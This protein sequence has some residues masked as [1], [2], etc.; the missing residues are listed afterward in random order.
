MLETPRR[1]SRPF[2]ST[3]DPAFRQVAATEGCRE[4]DS[5][6]DVWSDAIAE[7]GTRRE[8]CPLVTI[9]ADNPRIEAKLT[10][11]IYR[12]RVAEDGAVVS[13]K[14]CACQCDSTAQN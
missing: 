1:S 12:S 2:A 13:G 7:T 6:C 4:E 14:C 11:R 9:A 8:L 5:Y 3:H 10:L